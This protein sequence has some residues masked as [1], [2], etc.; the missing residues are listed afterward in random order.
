MDIDPISLQTDHWL[1][2]SNLWLD[3]ANF[4]RHRGT[5]AWHGSV[6]YQVTSN[7]RI[8]SA[9]CEQLVAFLQ[10]WI[11]VHGPSSQPFP[12]LELGAGH[13]TFTLMM[14][15]QLALRQPQLQALGIRLQYIMTDLA[16]DNLR[17][18]QQDPALRPWLQ[19]GQLQI[20]CF[21]C[22]N[23]QELQIHGQSVSYPSLPWLVIANYLF[24]S[25]PHD[26]FS[27]VGVGIQRAQAK[28]HQPDDE[29]ASWQ[30]TLNFV[31]FDMASLQL[32]LRGLLQHYQASGLQGCL[33]LPTGALRCIE[34]LRELSQDQLFLLCSDKGLSTAQSVSSR[35][36]EELTQFVSSSMLVNLHALMLY[37]Q[38][39]G[40]QALMQS[41][42]QDYLV[43]AAFCLC[44]SVSQLPHARQAFVHHLDR[45]SPGDL[46][47]LA[48]LLLAR[49]FDLSLT[50]MLSIIKLMEWDPAIFDGLYDALLA[51]LPRAGN[52]EKTDLLTALPLIAA[53]R[54]PLPGSA[55][56]LFR[57]AHLLQTM[58]HH[59][60]AIELYLARI[61]ERG[62]SPET[63][64]NLGLCYIAQ[65]QSELAKAAFLRA[66]ELD[67]SLLVA[68]GWLYRL[69]H[70]IESQSADWSP[71][72][73]R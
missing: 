46:Y 41:T 36:C 1:G 47:S 8:A 67:P 4:Y 20:A 70:G 15:R 19:S 49:R 56:T 43:S 16:S 45:N 51:C 59:P 29:P 24:D 35:N 55:D 44:R 63:C 61:E 30:L 23:Q 31:D 65:Q 60:S 2:E 18:W 72:R 34:N 52:N 64:Y 50:N 10:D 28:L 38:H 40:G 32:P 9:Y 5:S 27:L 33:L 53:R 66:S 17:A 12:I 25:L 73:A 69:Q 71:V 22:L 14:M 58:G 3:L 13:G 68:Q 6:P 54:Y 42:Q 57:I 21:D 11:A 37:F 48:M 7:P 62:E 39:E 26:A